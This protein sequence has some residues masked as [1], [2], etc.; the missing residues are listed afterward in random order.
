MIY[1]SLDKTKLWKYRININDSF[2]LTHK[3]DSA[4]A[5]HGNYKCGI[6]DIFTSTQ[7]SATELRAVT[8][9]V[10][11]T[12]YYGCFASTTWNLRQHIQ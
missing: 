5:I 7:N 3:A 10:I 2:V 9:S 6:Q 12:S 1:D 4:D 8:D 11:H